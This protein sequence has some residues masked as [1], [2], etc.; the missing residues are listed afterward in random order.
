M[1]HSNL[2]RIDGV[3]LSLR[4]AQP[5]DAA[6]I[7]ALR[8]DPTYNAH[9]SV[10]TGTVQ[11]Q[12]DWLRRYKIR[13]ADGSEYYYVIERRLDAQPCGL[14]RLYDITSDQFTWGSWILDHNKPPKAALE[15]AILIYQIGFERLGKSLSV[16][17]VRGDNARTLAFHTRFGAIETGSDGQDVFFNYHATQFAK[18]FDSHMAALTPSSLE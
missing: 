10:V 17:D 16:F 18:D 2:A 7:H 14:V 15:S 4:L 8:M 12:A 1:Q 11:N 6:Y 3:S 9:L 5:Q 13:E